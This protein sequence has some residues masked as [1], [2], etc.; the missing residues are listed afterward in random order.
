MHYFV[1][2]FGQNKYFSSLSQLLG[3]SWPLQ[4]SGGTEAIKDIGFL[5]EENCYS[6][7]PHE[8]KKIQGG[9]LLALLATF[10][11]GGFFRSIVFRRNQDAS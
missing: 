7:N 9:L 2:D 10:S 11:L 4:L 5:V 8:V 1:S 6:R 3:S